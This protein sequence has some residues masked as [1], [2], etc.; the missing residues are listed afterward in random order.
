MLARMGLSTVLLLQLDSGGT[1]R[2]NL[3]EI[4]CLRVLVFLLA[5]RESY[6]A[7]YAKEMRFHIA[8]PISLKSSKLLDLTR[9]TCLLAIYL[10]V[11]LRKF[12]IFLESK[13]MYFIEL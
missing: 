5:M 9:L 2:V 12:L 11:K 10:A 7:W 6:L 3:A 13:A 8:S 4:F 1:L